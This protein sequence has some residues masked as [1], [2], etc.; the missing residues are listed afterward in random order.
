[1]PAQT[2]AI[3]STKMHS[4]ILSAPMPPYSS[5][6]TIPSSPSSPSIGRTS[7]GNFSL[8]SASSTSGSDLSL[9]EL[10]DHL[11]EV[12][13]LLREGV[14]QHPATSGGS[15]CRRRGAAPTRPGQSSARGGIDSPDRERS[16]L[17]R[18]AHDHRHRGLARDRR[19]GRPGDRRPRAAGWCWWPAR[20]SALEELAGELAGPGRGGRRRRRRHRDRGRRARRRRGGSAASGAWSTTPGSTPSTTRSSRPRC[21]SGTRSCGSTCSGAAR[22]RPRRRPAPRRGRRGRAD[23]QPGLDRRA[24]PACPTS[25]PTTPPRRRSTRSRAPWRSSS[26]RPGCSATRSPRGRSPPRWSRA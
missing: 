19:R 20:G 22:L 7:T 26:A 10:A 16:L 21:R 3:S 6:K 15:G 25:A 12:V 24:S 14:A 18:R 2:L 8:R 9:G 1:M 13:L 4:V 11:A 17:A 5:G 23:H